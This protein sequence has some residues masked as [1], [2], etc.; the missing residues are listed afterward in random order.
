MVWL[1]LVEGLARGWPK[2]IDCSLWDDNDSTP[3]HFNADKAIAQGVKGV[4]PKASQGTWA[5]HDILYNYAAFEGKAHRSLFHFL[6]WSETGFTQAKFFCGVVKN[7]GADL[8]LVVDYEC[9]TN[10][11]TAGYAR[12]QLK[13]FVVECEQNL[14]SKLML[15]TS[16][17]YWTEFGSA[18]G[19]WLEHFPHLWIAH[20]IN[21]AYPTTPAPFT[22]WTFWQHSDKGFDNTPQGLMYGSEA[23]EIDCNYFNG[24]LAQLDALASGSILPP[25]PPPPPSSKT[26]NSKGMQINIRNAPAIL[27]TT[28]VGDALLTRADVIEELPDW[29]VFKAYVA[30]SVTAPNP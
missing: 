14:G 8:P 2:L 20:Y 25:P 10:P 22:S 13:N 7:L 12:T 21:R 16:P 27:S 18:D 3:Q 5:D 1:P 29:Y 17:S 26:I 6:D 11:P 9:R 24:T 4:F 28:D 15:Y 30:K 19:W 23:L